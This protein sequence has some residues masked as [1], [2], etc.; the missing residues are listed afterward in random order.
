MNKIFLFT[1][2][3][4]FFCS[5]SDL[6]GDVSVCGNLVNQTWV[7]ANS[8]YLVTCDLL[9][10]SL[11]IEPGV[12]VI[13]QGNYKIVV[14]GTGTLKAAGTTTDPIIFTAQTTWQGILFNKAPSG[15][16]LVHCV[17]ENANAG[18]IRFIQSTQV[19]MDC[20]ISGS[21]TARWFTTPARGSGTWA[22]KRR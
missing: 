21:Q 8:P 20:I 17:I 4:F 12:K 5:L 11:T 6:Y 2:S 14:T 10:S 16:V 1:L 18:G 15:S 3:L 22:S 13:A 7:K 9:I 19:L